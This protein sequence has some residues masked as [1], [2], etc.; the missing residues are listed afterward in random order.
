MNN[1][2]TFNIT[3]VYSV[4]ILFAG[5]IG[6]SG[7]N[8][9]QHPQQA[10]QQPVQQYQQQVPQ[11]QLYDANGNPVSVPVQQAPQQYYPQQQQHSSGLST[12]E[13]V[14]AVAG[15]GALAGLAY[16]AGKN[17]AE[18]K[19]KAVTVQKPTAPIYQSYGRDDRSKY[20]YVPPGPAVVK[21]S[22]VPST[23]PSYSTP[24]TQAPSAAASKS[25][26]APKAAKNTATV[27]APKS[28]FSF[29]KR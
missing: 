10:Y 5:A 6:I 21:P 29:K 13:V 9:N 22:Y 16:M 12:G 17:N 27:T 20:T 7:C 18:T 15:A 8:D 4:G 24:P 2:K 25:F 3:F 23:K 19:N 26:F 1:K 28:S 14:G 11:Q